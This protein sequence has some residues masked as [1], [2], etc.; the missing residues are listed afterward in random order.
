MKNKMRGN[1]HILKCGKELTQVQDEL[2]TDVAVGS[3][4]KKVFSLQM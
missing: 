2:C 3:C 4:L 1:V